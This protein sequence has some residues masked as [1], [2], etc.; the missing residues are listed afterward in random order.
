MIKEEE[1]GEGQKQRVTAANQQL[2]GCFGV[3][4][5][6]S[7]SLFRPAVEFQL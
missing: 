6:L 1:K 3:A 5:A 2:P 4:H 7:I